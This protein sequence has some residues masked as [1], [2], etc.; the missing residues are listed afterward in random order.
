MR[1]LAVKV[2]ARGDGACEGWR[3]GR[4]CN[5]SGSVRR[6]TVQRKSIFLPFLVLP[7]AG[8][9]HETNSFVIFQLLLFLTVGCGIVDQHSYFLLEFLHVCCVNEGGHSC[10]ALVEERNQLEWIYLCLRTGH[11]EVGHEG[12]RSWSICRQCESTL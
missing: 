4:G 9:V 10:S 3:E 6:K 8:Q 2:V 7:T 1:S 12:H 11:T 5:I